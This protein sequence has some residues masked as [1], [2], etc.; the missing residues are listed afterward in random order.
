MHVCPAGA[1]AKWHDNESCAPLALSS[2][3]DFSTSIAECLSLSRINQHPTSDLSYQVGASSSDP[4]FLRIMIQKLADLYTYTT[5]GHFADN[6]H[7]ARGEV[8]ADDIF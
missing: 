2:L 6:V 8:K 4:L 1:G 5:Y 3:P 7:D